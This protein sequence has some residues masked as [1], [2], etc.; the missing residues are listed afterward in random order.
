MNKIIREILEKHSIV[1]PSASLKMQNHEAN[2]KRAI[3]EI[4]KEQKKLDAD[5]YPPARDLI[6]NA[7]NIAE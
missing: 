3:I 1:I 2:M 7:I 4:C 6:L 5:V